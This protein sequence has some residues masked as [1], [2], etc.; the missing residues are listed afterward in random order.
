MDADQDWMAILLPVLQSFLLQ[1]QYM[2]L[3]LILEVATTR[4]LGITAGDVDV[5]LTAGAAG[6]TGLVEVK[7]VVDP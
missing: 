6:I 4:L 2:T 5:P 7:V 3:L 1:K